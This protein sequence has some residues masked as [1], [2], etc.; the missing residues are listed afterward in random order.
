MC[1]KLLIETKKQKKNT[2]QQF[3][4]KQIDVANQHNTMLRNTTTITLE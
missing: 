4:V 1:S 2:K 3:V